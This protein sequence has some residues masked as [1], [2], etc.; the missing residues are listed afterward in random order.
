MGVSV[1]LLDVVVDVEL[2]V[3]DRLVPAYATSVPDIAEQA[4]MQLGHVS[5]GHSLARAKADRS[6]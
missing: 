1:Q 6:T 4:R 2:A 3:D 5:T